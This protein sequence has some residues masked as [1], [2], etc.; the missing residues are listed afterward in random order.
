MKIVSVLMV[1]SFCV[2]DLSAANWPMWR[3]PN[4]NGVAVGKNYP[5]KWSNTENIVWKAVLPAAGSSTPAVWENRIFVTC[6][7]GGKNLVFCFDRNGKKLWETAVGENSPGT[8]RQG[9]G[10]NPSPTTDGKHVYV[11]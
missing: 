3:G 2:G 9:S 1:L 5:I 11:D 10:S 4:L 8:D 6:P 7:G